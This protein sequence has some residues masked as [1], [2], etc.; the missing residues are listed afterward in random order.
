MA[1]LYFLPLE[2]TPSAIRMDGRLI[3]LSWQAERTQDPSEPEASLLRR[4][5]ETLRGPELESSGGPGA[6]WQQ[7][8]L[9]EA[10]SDI[11]RDWQTK[12]GISG[13]G[14]LLETYPNGCALVRPSPVTLSLNVT[15]QCNI[16]C[17]YC[18]FSG[19]YGGNRRHNNS[20]LADRATDLAIQRFFSDSGGAAPSCL[21]IFGG[22]PLMALAQIRHAFEQADHLGI[23]VLKSMATNGMLL[24]EAAVQLFAK[25]E[26]CI[27]ISL[28]GPDHDR[29]RIH[30]NGSGSRRIV[31]ERLDWLLATFPDFLRTS[32]S[33]S[34]VVTADT[35]LVALFNYFR[36]S[37]PLREAL[38]WDFDIVLSG[39]GENEIF[40]VAEQS[41]EL[42]VDWYLDFVTQCDDD[43]SEEVCWRYF[44]ASGFNMIHRTFWAVATR[45][46]RRQQAGSVRG[47]LGT[48][49]PPGGSMITVRPNGDLVVGN[50]R[51][52]ISYVVG[53][54]ETGLDPARVQR[55]AERFERAIDRI[56]CQLCWAAPMCT[57]T[58]SDFDVDDFDDTAPTRDMTLYYQRCVLERRLIGA[59]SE[60][61]L[62]LSPAD[63][64]RC[65]SFVRNELAAMP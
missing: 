17:T 58:L 5:Q 32:V 44:F 4:L 10:E 56:G 37:A 38:H 19:G 20:Y 61:L 18:Y 23:N 45:D 41:L 35:D 9:T 47:V 11:L 31:E 50:E 8:D 60:R 46:A 28:D 57:L 14:W 21:Y 1:E 63:R 29:A 26:V 65:Y 54:V 40:D 16:A 51:Q 12:S 2:P 3:F 7:S 43:A 25:H 64:Q 13:G 30:R 34:C 59:F 55:L 42:L 52:K 49:S 39:L 53:S 22:E 15:E 48:V 33:I 6:H 24:D 27:A 36:N 62:K